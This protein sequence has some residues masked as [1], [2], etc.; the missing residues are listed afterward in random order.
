M[1]EEIMDTKKV[2]LST[3]SDEGMNV[4]E[5]SKALGSR[6]IDVSEEE[7]TL[8]LEG[9]QESG[10]I[11]SNGDGSSVT[12]LGIFS[13]LNL[14]DVCE[15]ITSREDIFNFF[16]TRIPATIPQELLSKFKYSDDFRII[17]E[18]DFAD[19]MTYLLNDA[20][21]TLPVAKREVIVAVDKLFR[22]GFLY[23]IGMVRHRPKM[24]GLFS[25]DDFGR[26]IT[27]LKMALKFVN[28]ELKVTDVKGQSLGAYIVD[29]KY[30][31]FGFRT[32]EGVP[33]HDALLAT[34]DEECIKWV[35]ENF[36]YA[37]ENFGRMP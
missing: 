31:L 33:G 18:P 32:L 29:D 15:S 23:L 16:R 12:L 21:A 19:R 6:G 1:R 10:L 13:S 30:C 20:I 24:M 27:F 22:P 11:F 35:R 25:E 37:W 8:L 4:E 34:E 14:Y 28:M 17:G 2:I 26:E 36:E 7:I 5:L 3:L 9:L